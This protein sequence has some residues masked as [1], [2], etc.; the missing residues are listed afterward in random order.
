MRGEE[1]AHA[2][3][4]GQRLAVEVGGLDLGHG[5]VGQH[6]DEPVDRAQRQMQVA[7]FQRLDLRRC[8][9][10]RDAVAAP[11]FRSRAGA[12]GDGCIGHR[13]VMAQHRGGVRIGQMGAGIGDADLL[14]ARPV[15]TRRMGGHGRQHRRTFARH[16]RAQQ[17]AVAGQPLAPTLPRLV[18]AAP[19]QRG[20]AGRIDIEIRVRGAP[21]CTA[22]AVTWP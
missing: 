10:D 11:G 12:D 17:N 4:L 6:V 5:G 2:F 14:S 21:C 13:P 19:Q 3:R 22:I 15:P 7:P 8:I 16:L 9:A 18:D 20:G 1:V